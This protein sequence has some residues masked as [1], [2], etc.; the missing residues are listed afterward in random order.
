MKK[1]IK[2]GNKSKS[3]PKQKRLKF[4]FKETKCCS[5]TQVRRQAVP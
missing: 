2:M 5:V 4:A 1:I 3:L